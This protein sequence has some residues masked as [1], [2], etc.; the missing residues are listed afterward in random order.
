MKLDPD[1][2]HKISSR[3]IIDLNVKTWTTNILEENIRIS[4]LIL[5]QAK[6]F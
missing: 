6:I 4:F 2:V 5:E 3:W 1:A